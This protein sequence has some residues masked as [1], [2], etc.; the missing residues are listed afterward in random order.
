MST[1]KSAERVLSLFE[2]FAHHQ[3]SATVTEITRAL[4]IPQSSA[5]M[6]TRSLVELGYLE[7][8]PNQ[9]TYFPTLRIA[10]LSEWMHR[11]SAMFGALSRLLDSVRTETDETVIL[12]IR[13]DIYAQNILVQDSPDPLRLHVRS[14]DFHPLVRCAPGWVFLS[15][16]SDRDVRMIARRSN[17]EVRDKK[18]V[19]PEAQ[20]LEKVQ[21][22]RDRGY[23]KADGGMTA[24]AG[25]ISVA[26]PI[27]TGQ[28]P[29]AV[30][31][32]GP[33]D[34]LSEKQ[35]LILRSL[36]RLRENFC[37]GRLSDEARR[38]GDSVFH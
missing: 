21:E 38:A 28:K 11:R 32:G 25:S 9:R 30:S 10:L 35:E 24:D 14:G 29:L 19:T 12:S 6:L 2:Y 20:V 1:I 5:S 33:S 23:A 3:T 34:R 8:G 17:G 16:L 22:T 18:L 26:L 4:N 31:V 13:N 36:T 27:P 37:N 7:R 15:M